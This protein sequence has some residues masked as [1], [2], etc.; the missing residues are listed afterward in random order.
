ML[1]AWGKQLTVDSADD[2]RVSQ[3]FTKYVQGAQTPEPG[4]ACT[5]G[6]GAQ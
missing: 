6:L 5:G 1:S 2:P 3:F 4:A